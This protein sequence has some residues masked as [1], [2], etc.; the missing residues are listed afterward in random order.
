SFSP[1][2][3]Q[4]SNWK[5]TIGFSPWESCQRQLTERVRGIIRPNLL[6]RQPNGCHLPRWGR[7]I[8]AVHTVTE[9]S[10]L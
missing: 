9:I 10:H 6:I 3:K 8:F 4:I 7:L 1:C 2:E 5:V